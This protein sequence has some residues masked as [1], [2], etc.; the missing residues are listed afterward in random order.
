M[1]QSL[2][3]ELAFGLS[4]ATFLI[5]YQSKVGSTSKF[6]QKWFPTYVAH[7]SGM[8]CYIS[9]MLGLDCFPL[10]RFPPTSR[11]GLLECSTSIGIKIF[12]YY[13]KY[14]AIL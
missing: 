6:P 7:T 3:F 1:W 8:S 14:V 12:G 5:W 10:D 4:Y 2:T 11:K 13:K 9:E